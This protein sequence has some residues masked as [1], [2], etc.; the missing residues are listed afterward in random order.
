M[1]IASSV[2]VRRSLF[3]LGALLLTGAVGC[4]GSGKGTVTGKV[5]L[6]GKPLPAGKIS[7]VGASGKAATADISDGQYTATNVPTGDVKVTVQTSPI[8]QEAD[9]L[10]AS[11]RYSS[12]GRSRVPA[13]KLPANVREHVQEEAARNAEMLKK[14][15]ELLARYRPVP[16]KYGKP[17]SSGLHVSVTRGEN[18]FDVPLTSH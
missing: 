5:T 13:S 17:D 3:L 9:R 18:S 6:D 16:D 1:C 12:A 11:G 10:L 15:K 2:P 7:F 8:K 4:G 14:G